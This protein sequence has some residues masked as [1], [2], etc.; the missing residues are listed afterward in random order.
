MRSSGGAESAP[1][2]ERSSLG[3]GAADGRCARCES[4]PAVKRGGGTLHL[5]LPVA[6][7]ATKVRR[8]AA[9]SGW[10]VRADGAHFAIDVPAGDLS[11]YGRALYDA[12][13]SVERE[14]TRALFVEHGHEPSIGDY[15]DA[16][17]LQRFVARS[18]LDDVA[19][20]L[21]GDMLSAAFQP[22]VETQTLR[23]FAHEGLIRIAPESRIAGPA[24]LFRIARDTD[25]LPTADLAA[26]KTIISAAA[27]QAF[28]GNLFINFMPSSI[29]DASSCL[30]STIALLDERRITPDRVV[31]EVVE[32]DEVA[33]VPHLLKTLDVYRRSGFRV[34]L[35]DVGA[36]F[37]S[38]NLLHALK[39]DFIK[40]DLEL[41]RDV[42]HDAFK[43]M[44]AAKLIEAGLALGIGVIAEGVETEAE[45]AWLREHGATYVQGFYFARP[46]PQMLADDLIRV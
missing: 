34:A 9:A 43:A 10:T 40:L 11:V 28:R 17:T 26:R 24:D 37:A 5:K 38:L 7:T 8:L 4:I 3:N 20:A 21:G 19:C 22:I 29:Y 18:R 41:V 12:C 30:R 27:A 2:C 36:G 46:A 35:D 6:G 15:L 32:S 16:D 13:S 39:P 1:V 45:W 31:F 44:L 25:T 42:D 23:T 14:S 33:D